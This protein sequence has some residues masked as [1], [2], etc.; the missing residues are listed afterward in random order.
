[1]Q[2]CHLGLPVRD[3]QRSLD[4]YATNFDFD[5]ATATHYEDGTVI[6]RDANRFD[7]AL[8]VE[9]DSS[10]PGPSTTTQ[11]LGPLHPFLH[12]GFRPRNPQGV[13]ELLTRMEADG[14]QITERHDE[15]G[16]LAFKCADP[17]G[18]RVEVYWEE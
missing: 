16:Y 3:I 11:L 8:Q 2:L 9:L 6:V 18:H 12:F 17:D 13:R 14:V 5:R 7:L 1:M 4:F 10:D 15:H